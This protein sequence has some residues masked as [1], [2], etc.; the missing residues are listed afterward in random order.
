MLVASKSARA[1]AEDGLFPRFFATTNSRGVNQTGLLVLSLVMTLMCLGAVT[2]SS[3]TNT[4]DLMSSL[5]SILTM[6]PYLC[7]ALSLPTLVRGGTNVTWRVIALT[8][9]AYCVLAL[10]GSPASHLLLA[11]FC[12]AAVLASYRY[13]SPTVVDIQNFTI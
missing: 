9:I 5:S 10:L 3:S 7:T 1:A 11:A 6:A 8:A 2:V 13:M 12:A 4:F